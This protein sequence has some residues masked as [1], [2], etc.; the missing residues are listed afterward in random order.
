[1]K[2]TYFIC[3]LPS[4]LSLLYV[5]VIVSMQHCNMSVKLK[6]SQ[7]LK[8]KT[9]LF[10]NSTVYKT[11]ISIFFRMIVTRTTCIRARYLPA[12]SCVFQIDD[13]HINI[14]WTPPTQPGGPISSYNLHIRQLRVR[15]GEVNQ[16]N[17]GY[18]HTTSIQFPVPMQ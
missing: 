18:V 1:M 10:Q 11:L 9:I 2:S 5:V 4:S 14:T 13:L 3:S 17:F 12:T 7:P 16:K 8:S 6:R 15:S